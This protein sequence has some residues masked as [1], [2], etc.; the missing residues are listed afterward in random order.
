MATT[1]AYRDRLAAMQEFLRKHDG[2]QEFREAVVS[3]M[4]HYPTEGMHDALAALLAES[5]ATD[6]PTSDG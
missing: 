5:P 4:A 6:N 2:W 1:E 3:S